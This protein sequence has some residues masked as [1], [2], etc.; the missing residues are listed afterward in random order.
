MAYF[1][2]EDYSR[3]SLKSHSYWSLVGDTFKANLKDRKLPNLTSLILPEKTWLLCSIAELQHAR[4][5][6]KGNNKVKWKLAF[7]LFSPGCPPPPPL[8]KA[9]KPIP[10]PC[11]EFLGGAQAGGTAR[12]LGGK[13]RSALWFWAKKIAG[14]CHGSVCIRSKYFQFHAFLC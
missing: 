11:P 10:G 9:G 4:R 2:K 7:P 1:W 13:R 6:L 12:D 5:K 8:T 3:I 14:P